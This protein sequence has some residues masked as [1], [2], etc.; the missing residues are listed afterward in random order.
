MKFFTS[1]I[2][3]CSET[4]MKSDNRPFKSIKEYDN[5]ILNNFNKM[6]KKDDTIYIAGDLLDCNGPYTDE[7]LKGLKLI[8]KIKAKV[9]LIIGNNENRIIKYFFNGD[10][11]A[12]ADHCKQ[13]G[14]SEVYKSLDVEFAGKK[15]HLVHQIKDGDKRKIN[16][17]GH[18]H[19]CSGLY[20]PYGLCISTD[21]NH[22]RLFTEEILL[23]YLKRK[24]QYWE[25]DE[26]TNYINPFIKQV[27]G[28]WINIKLK[29]NKMYQEYLKNNK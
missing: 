15:F 1:D 17:F 9:V 5:F 29:N 3:F 25:P 24:T 4:T 23:G 16:L 19:L 21:L 18:T 27:N 10:F 2:H 20:H 11:D 12:F 8:K 7:W 26:N 6:A 22:F 13:N 14:I 28:K